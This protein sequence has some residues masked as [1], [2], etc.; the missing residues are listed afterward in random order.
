MII[1]I[2]MLIVMRKASVYPNNQFASRK[3]D[4][5]FFS[6]WYIAEQT[7]T[8]LEQEGDYNVD[9]VNCITSIH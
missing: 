7:H 5:F 2:I 9:H 8:H 1:I 3:L 4:T 6:I